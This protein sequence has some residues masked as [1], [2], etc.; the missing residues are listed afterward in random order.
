[1]YHFNVIFGSQSSSSSEKMD[2]FELK[3][4]VLVDGTYKTDAMVLYGIRTLGIEF[5]HYA[6][7]TC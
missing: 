6:K 7:T 3:R 4:G 5:A 2:V 1:M